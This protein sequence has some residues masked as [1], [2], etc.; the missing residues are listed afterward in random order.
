M[1]EPAPAAT[2]Q[3]PTPRRRG[4]GAGSLFASSR[5]AG[6]AD[7]VNRANPT[8]SGLAT[9]GGHARG[10]AL[11]LGATLLY[12][13][14]LAGPKWLP[15]YDCVVL[16][17][18]IAGVFW[19]FDRF[20]PPVRAGALLGV[21]AILVGAFL[22]RLWTLGYEG[23]NA[24]FGGILP[25]SDSADFYSDALR[26]VHGERLS[27]I[28][29]RRPLF[30]ALLAGLLKLSAGNLRVSLALLAALAAVSTALPALEVWRTDGW[31]SASV[32]YLVLLFFE[33]RWTGFI[34][35][36]HFGLPL[37][38]A[39][40][41]LLWRAQSLRG[42]NVRAALFAAALGVF[43][44]S[45][46]LFARAGCF[47]VLPALLVWGAGLAPPARRSRA[48]ALLVCAALMAFGI[49]EAVLVVSANGISF[50]DYPP[51][52]YGLLH[53]KDFTYLAQTHRWL[54]DL[55]PADRI[56][57]QWG[58]VLDEIRD[59]PWTVPVAFARSL[60]AFFVSPFGAFSYV[61]TNPDDAFFEDR[62]RLDAMWQS[63]GPTA[64]VRYWQ[65]SLGSFSIVNTVVM[66]ALGAAFVIAFVV[67]LIRLA[68]HAR[69]PES[70]L[71]VAASTGIVTSVPFMPPWI[72]S[73]VQIQTVTLAFAAAVAARQLSKRDSVAA[74]RVPFPRAV[75]LGLP[76]GVTIFGM[77]LAWVLLTPEH[78]P[79]RAAADLHWVEVAPAAS[80]E[81]A[82]RRRWSFRAKGL[83]DLASSLEFLSKHN[84]DLTGSVATS[85]KVGVLF[86]SVYDPA[87][88]HWEILVDEA[89]KLDGQVGW[90]A[91]RSTPMRSPR[92][93]ML[94]EAPS[95]F[96]G[97]AS[98]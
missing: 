36:E 79:G 61:W 89:Q 83:T 92:V 20:D 39:G 64:V 1:S 63:G 18:L 52:F 57:A 42:T 44:L 35:T 53:G 96:R 66:G 16:P 49:H 65:D 21:S 60:L 76:G 15:L 19:T 9:P 3:A 87:A 70:S 41:V 84:E 40:F 17:A 37:G 54:E 29:S 22:L 34:Q 28:S 25:W 91:V 26:L 97:L 82:P 5:L 58:I 74:R 12:A 81:V 80:V 71:L 68:R 86:H 11:A 24:V 48:V 31:K 27:P 2:P 78:P 51:I 13:L 98:P 50:S 4:L 32:V 14:A 30:A 47:F 59:R 93:Q 10:R 43:A 46:G 77:L 23:R 6:L 95:R 88:G 33:R 72:T 94:L 73:G 7:L 8:R 55:A 62:P 67:G 38:A 90:V 45:L 75:A 69:D 56:S 85:M